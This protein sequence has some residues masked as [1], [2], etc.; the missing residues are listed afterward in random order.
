MDSEIVLL[1]MEDQFET[2]SPNASWDFKIE[3]LF[4]P[5]DA[6]GNYVVSVGKSQQYTQWSGTDESNYGNNLCSHPDDP[7]I[8]ITSES[9]ANDASARPDLRF[10]SGSYSGE[11]G[12]F[13]GLEPVYLSFAVRNSGNRPVAPDDLINAQ[14]LLSKDLIK[15]TS[16]FVL[17]EFNLGGDGIGQGLLA[18]ETI[19]LTWF[20]QMPD[21]FE[22]DYYLI[23]AIDNLGTESTSYI[24]ST[25][26]ISL[27]SQDSG[28]TSI[29]DTS[30]GGV[31]KPA[32]R[33]DASE[34]GR[35]VTFEKTQFVN[36][37]DLQQIYIIDMEQPDPEPKLISRAY[38]SSL[39]FPAPANGGSFRP[40]ISADGTAVV[41]HSNASNLVQ[42]IPIIKK[43]F[44]FIACPQIPCSVQWFPRIMVPPP[45][46]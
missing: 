2:L 37:R 19:N 40:K 15:D 35:F 38:N 24:D 12:S 21:N 43:M 6:S 36:G 46:S 31:S 32:E 26:M 23:I 33:P 11:R 16:D 45:S 1:P 9:D 20:Q 14:I 18:G 44:F 29:L 34:G 17:R 25:P 39:L 22:G 27:A 3:N 30:V 42:G 5:P 41:F 28:T 10:V 13:R 7:Y 8:N 4:L